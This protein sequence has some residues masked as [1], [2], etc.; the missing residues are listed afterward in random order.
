MRNLVS[1]G[2]LWG[3]VLVA[4]IASAKDREPRIRS[5]ILRDGPDQVAHQIYVAG[6]VATVLRFEKAVA[7]T[8]TKIE[9]WEGRFEPLSVT[10]SM[11]V[12]VPLYDLTPADRLPLVVTMVDG[13]Q[14]PFIVTAGEASVDH[15]VNLVWDRDSD[16]FLRA[17]LV[18]A[19][20]KERFYRELVEKY[21][22][23]DTIDHAL[24]ALLAK[25]ANKMT[26][27]HEDKSW[28]LNDE[29]DGA[30]IQVFVYSSKQRDKAAVVF[31]VQNHNP[32]PWRLLE[33][34]LRTTQEE[35]R[36]F[37]MRTSE[38]SVR[39]GARGR[40]AFVIDAQAF[41][42]SE[43]PER[44]VLEIFRQDGLKE[45]VVELDPSLLR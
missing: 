23:E 15:Q 13:T 18:D 2:V 42:G 43:G 10:G 21:E 3:A 29:G 44:L 20:V 38:A 11:V 6:E 40:V 5:V 17:S 39:E 34:R 12:L 1:G 24:A 30:E 41:D 45:A 22:Q 19:R 25:G 26:P 7:P 9:G 31:S 33:A 27:F 36:P 4:S 14:W 35:K 16:R 37:A 8:R 32:E 28:L